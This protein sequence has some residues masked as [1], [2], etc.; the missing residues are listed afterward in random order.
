MRAAILDRLSEKYG[1]LPYTRLERHHVL[2]IRDELADRPEAANAMLKALR[3][4]FKHG[5][6]Y[7]ASGILVNPTSDIPYFKSNNPM[8]HHSW[9]LEEVLQFEAKHPIGTK[10]RLAMALLLY[11]GQR[12]SDIVVLGRQHVKE[13]RLEFI[14]HKNRKSKP[15][16]LS[17]PILP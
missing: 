1:H 9:T 13:G 16:Q 2:K 12:R 14:Q 8:G 6:N 3:Q 5:I 15:V 7:D 11:T 4:V 10:V 17:I